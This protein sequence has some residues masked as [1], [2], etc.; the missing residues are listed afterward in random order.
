M[1]PSELLAA[2]D[3]LVECGDCRQSLARIVPDAAGSAGLWRAL[4]SSE[5]PASRHLS[6][7]ELA[8]FAE[9]DWSKADRQQVTVHLERCPQCSEDA[10]D[11]RKFRDDLAQPPLVSVT[12]APVTEVIARRR[13]FFTVPVWAGA[14]ARRHR[15]GF[16]WTACDSSVLRP[17]R[18]EE[19]QRRSR[20]Q[21]D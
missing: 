7:E 3:H 2:D 20:E 9:N 16:R 5:P 1:P 14:A 17:Q 6:H 10:E 18:R 19:D 4:T 15:I 11:L 8:A 21:A 12:K 13:S